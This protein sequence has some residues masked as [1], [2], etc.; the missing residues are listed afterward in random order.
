MADDIIEIDD[1]EVKDRQIIETDNEDY[2]RDYN[3]REYDGY[4][5]QGSVNGFY[6]SIS[7]SNTSLLIIIMVIVLLVAIFIMTFD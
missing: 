6:K 2:K 4:D 1:Y 3:Q 7:F 5:N